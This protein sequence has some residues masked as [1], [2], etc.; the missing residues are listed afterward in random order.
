MRTSCVC[1]PPQWHPLDPR[2]RGDGDTPRRT[3]GTNPFPEPRRY[4]RAMSHLPPGRHSADVHGRTVGEIVI[5][6]LCLILP[7][8]PGRAF[9]LYEEAAGPNPAC[10]VHDSGG[11]LMSL[12]LSKNSAGGS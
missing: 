1:G 9:A 7:S 8:S 4:P 3:V 10:N 12:G 2:Y 11:K 6:A 5:F